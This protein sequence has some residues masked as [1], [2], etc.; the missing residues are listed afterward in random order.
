MPLSTVKRSKNVIAFGERV[1]DR[2]LRDFVPV[3]YDAVER[4]FREIVLDFRNCDRAYADAVLPII[5]LLD[6]RRRRGSTFEALL[7]ESASLRQLFLN[8]NLGPLH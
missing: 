4:G 7:P 2:T 6:H 1:N 8:A 5:C 3:L